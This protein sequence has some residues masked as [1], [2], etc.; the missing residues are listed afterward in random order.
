MQITAKLQAAFT[1]IISDNLMKVK[2]FSWES[3]LRI[4]TAMVATCHRTVPEW[5]DS[6][7]LALLEQNL[8]KIKRIIFAVSLKWS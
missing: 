3:M 6:R 4:A 2:R 8:L 5:C 7:D 1:F